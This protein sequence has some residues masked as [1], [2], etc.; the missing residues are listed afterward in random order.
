ME[1]HPTADLLTWF[2][3]LIDH[4]IELESWSPSELV[5]K[6]TEE[7]GELSEQ[8]L[9]A[10]GRKQKVFDEP[11]EGEVADVINCAIAIHVRILMDQGCTSDEIK[12]RLYDGIF[13]K[14]NK[15]ISALAAQR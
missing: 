6:L 11:I 15:Y 4:L 12:S 2:D 1:T 9:V 5:T 7:A 14:N 10:T 3:D 8:V 13:V